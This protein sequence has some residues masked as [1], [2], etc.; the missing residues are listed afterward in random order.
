MN[1]INAHYP[2]LLVPLMALTFLAA[3]V[4]ATYKTLASKIFFAMLA[5]LTV[6]CMSI[7]VIR[8]WQQQSDL[9]HAM[10]LLMTVGFLGPIAVAVLRAYLAK[11][12]LGSAQE[13]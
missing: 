1:F 7:F 5:V 12:R 4:C 2:Q 11:R 8:V 9:D 10:G 3:F 13:S 6:C